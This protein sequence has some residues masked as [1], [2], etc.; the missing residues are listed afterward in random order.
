MAG[1]AHLSPWKAYPRCHQPCT[2]SRHNPEAVLK[3]I[4]SIVQAASRLSDLSDTPYEARASRWVEISLVWRL[5]IESRLP[6]AMYLSVACLRPTLS[7]RFHM[8]GVLGNW[9]IF[10]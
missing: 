2:Y 7:A 4:L 3:R 9:I 10:T 5:D 8:N 1:R 6:T